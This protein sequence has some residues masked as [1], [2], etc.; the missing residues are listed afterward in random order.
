[1]KNKMSVYVA[2]ELVNRIKHLHKALFQAEN[3]ISK[4]EEENHR[5][6]DALVSLASTNNQ[7]YV[8]DSETFNES[9]YTV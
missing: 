4:L 3:I 8:L 2:D 7:G 6:Q 5:L 9:V 1:M